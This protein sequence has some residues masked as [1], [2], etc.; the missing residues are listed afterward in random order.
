[1]IRL[2]DNPPIVWPDDALAEESRLD[3]VAVYS[4]PRQEKALAWDLQHKGVPYFLPMVLRET[5]SGGRRRRNLYPLFP[6]YLFVAGG[7]TEQLAAL[8]TNRTVKLVRPDK[9]G[10]ATLRHELTALAAALA[11]FPDSLELHPRLTPGAPARVRSGPM[12]GVEGVVIQVGSRHKLWLGISCLGVGA[13][14]EIHPDLVEA[15]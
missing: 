11:N 15:L 9:G 6:S 5:S 4:K 8:K 12:A 14:V 2:Q 7:E 13:T 1:M 3:W 10:E